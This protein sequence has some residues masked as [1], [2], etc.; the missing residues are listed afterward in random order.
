MYDKKGNLTPMGKKVMD[1]GKTASKRNEDVDLDEAAHDP[2]HVKMAIGIASDKR[3]KGG[4]MTGAVKSIEKIKKGLSDH[5][6]VS[7]VLRRQNEETKTESLDEMWGT[8]VSKRP[9]MLLDKNNKVKFDKR[10]KMFKKQNELEEEFTLNEEMDLVN[11]LENSVNEFVESNEFKEA[12][13]P[14]LSFK[15]IQKRMGKAK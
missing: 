14:K 2:K 3:Y 9:H 13:E 7:H 11:D 6:Q 4:N 1:Q 5:P 8:Y 10:F 12:T 15:D